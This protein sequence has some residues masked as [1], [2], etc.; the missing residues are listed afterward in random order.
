[1]KKYYNNNKYIIRKINM[2]YLKDKKN[3]SFAARLIPDAKLQGKYEFPVLE[4][5]VADVPMDIVPFE[6]R[7]KIK[8]KKEVFLH[9]YMEDR[10]F[11]K[12]MERPEKY[13]KELSKYGG[14]ISPDASMYVDMHLAEQIANS[15]KNKVC[16]VFFQQAGI[17]VIPNVRWAGKESFDFAFD[18]F[19]PNGVYAISTHGCIRSKQEKDMFK[20]G[21]QE[22][23]KR[24]NPKIILVHGAMPESVFGDFT[25][26]KFIRYPSWIE[27]KHRESEEMTRIKEMK[28]GNK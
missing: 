4:N 7:K 13:L 20:L 27:R 1:M 26:I 28:Y 23:I 9:F 17:N 16:A 5:T 8:N 14:V 10:R 24:L 6:K 22:M 11:K 25:N 12:I 2:K 18:G 15:F 21:L 19:M 3:I